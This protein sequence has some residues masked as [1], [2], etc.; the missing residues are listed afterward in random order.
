[1]IKQESD[2]TTARED[3]VN[4]TPT[5]S[6]SDKSALKQHRF[7]LHVAMSQRRAVYE[8]ANT[9][10]I[11]RLN[12][13]YS[14]TQLGSIAKTTTRHFHYLSNR[15]TQYSFPPKTSYGYPPHQF[16]NRAYTR[17]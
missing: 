12:N 6:A 3:S 15:V 13:I 2:S 5:I 14:P 4:K 8:R 17:M 11:H 9:R 7:Q 10:L 1:M 16:Y